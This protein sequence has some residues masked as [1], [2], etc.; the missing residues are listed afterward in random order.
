[1]GIC[2][3]SEVICVF[4]EGQRKLVQLAHIYQR[5]NGKFKAQPEPSSL[6]LCLLPNSEDN[7]CSIK[8]PTL[9]AATF[10]PSKQSLSAFYTL[11]YI[12]FNTKRQ[13][14]HNSILKYRMRRIRVC[15]IAFEPQ[16]I[17]L[18]NGSKAFLS[19]PNSHFIFSTHIHPQCPRKKKLNEH[20]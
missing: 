3:F 12:Q 18:M 8:E 16:V 17:H 7:I 4:S 2:I 1:M 14:K 10:H 9:G 13:L 11:S 5:H 19:M 20:V 15:H 6:Y